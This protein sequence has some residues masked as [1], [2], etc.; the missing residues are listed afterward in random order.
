[1]LEYRKFIRRAS[2]KIR[3]ISLANNIEKLAQ[4]VGTRILKTTN[5]IFFDPKTAV[6]NGKRVT[7]TYLVSPLRPTKSEVYR[8][9]I[10]N[11]SQ[12]VIVQLISILTHSHNMRDPLLIRAM[13]SPTSSGKLPLNPQQE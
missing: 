1:M 4:G 2:K 9:R 13:L 12:F 5:A 8:T 10:T 7:Y 11:S 3:E 6:A